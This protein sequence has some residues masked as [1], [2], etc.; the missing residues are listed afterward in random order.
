MSTEESE[1]RAIAG[2]MWNKLGDSK[3]AQLGLGADGVYREPDD[4][5]EAEHGN[6]IDAQTIR[7]KQQAD[8]F[9]E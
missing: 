8:A 3:F 2:N 7:K 5:E 9:V 1:N 4:F 6:D